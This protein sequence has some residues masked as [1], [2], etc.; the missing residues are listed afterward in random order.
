MGEGGGTSRLEREWGARSRQQQPS[1]DV[2]CTIQESHRSSASGDRPGPALSSPP[3]R[4]SLVIAPA[5]EM[6]MTGKRQI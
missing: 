3:P 6:A 4:Q 5:K 1:T 2:N